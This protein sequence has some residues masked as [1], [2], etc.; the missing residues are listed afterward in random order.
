MYICMQHILLTVCMNICMYVI[1]MYV[2]IESIQCMSVYMYVCLLVPSRM[3]VL[4]TNISKILFVNNRISAL[5]DSDFRQM[6]CL[7]RARRSDPMLAECLVPYDHILLVF[8]ASHPQQPLQHRRDH[9]YNWEQVNIRS[10]KNICAHCI[11][12]CMY[13]CMCMYVDVYL[14]GWVCKYLCMYT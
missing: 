14:N 5:Q 9:L 11:Y 10:I 13:I 3:Y 1:C 7:T 8:H 12:A 2:S 4:Y 6:V